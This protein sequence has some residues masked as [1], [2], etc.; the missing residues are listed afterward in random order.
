MESLFP[1]AATVFKEASEK[2]SGSSYSQGTFISLAC[3][4]DGL[5]PLI[6]VRELLSPHNRLRL[7]SVLAGAIRSHEMT[8]V[9]LVP[10]MGDLIDIIKIDFKQAKRLIIYDSSALEEILSW[11]LEYA[12]KNFSTKE[13]KKNAQIVYG[14]RIKAYLENSI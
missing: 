5:N 1:F 12:P 10:G 8:G 6:L 13:E 11:H 4:N 9:V 14:K 2:Y 7:N 3:K